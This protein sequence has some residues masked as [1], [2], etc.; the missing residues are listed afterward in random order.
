MVQQFGVRR[1]PSIA[2]LREF[3]LRF[4][5]GLPRLYHLQDGTQTKTKTFFRSLEFGAIGLQQTFLSF[6]LIPLSNSIEIG[7]ADSLADPAFGC[8]YLHVALIEAGSS[9]S[10]LADGKA[11]IEERKG[12]LHRYG[13][14][15]VAVVLAA[16]AIFLAVM[17]I[18]I[19]G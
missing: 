17:I 18:L 1:Q 19:T 5:F 13:S 15:T 8:F 14:T 16:T 12:K 10:A 6:A 3:L 9:F 2:G 7:A 4:R 11:A